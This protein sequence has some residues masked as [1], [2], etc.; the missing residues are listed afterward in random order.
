M[1]H[2]LTHRLNF[3]RICVDRH[4][5]IAGLTKRLR[6]VKTKFSQADHSKLSSSQVNPFPKKLTDQ[7][8]AFGITHARLFLRLKHRGAERQRAYATHE[9]R[10]GNHQFPK[11][12]EQSR[13]A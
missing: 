11:A 5:F 8:F 1:R 9:H 2:K 12:V 7:H 4:H 13:E 10:H 6:H 3:L